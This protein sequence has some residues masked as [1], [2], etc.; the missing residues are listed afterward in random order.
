MAQ[1]TKESE[2]NYLRRSAGGAWEASKP[3]P[4]PGHVANQEHAQHLLDFAVMLRVLGPGS[5]DRVLDLGAGSCWVSEWLR[6][7]GVRTVALDIA[8]DMLRLGA[9]RLGGP[10]GLVA[11][12]MEFLPFADHSFTKACCLNAFHHVP[13]TK[14]ALGEIR[15]VLTPD[16]VAFFS[17]P[18][19]GHAANPTSVAAARNYGVLENEILIEEFMDACLEAG[20]ADVRLHPISNVMPLFVLDRRQWRD[21]RQFTASTRPVR[22]LDK[23]WRA[24]L[25]FAGVGKKDLLF[26]EAFAIRLLRELE[27][28]IE[29][30]PIVTAHRAPFVKPVL[31]RDAA[32]ITLLDAPRTVR[33]GEAMSLAGR[34]DN[35]GTTTWNR[36]A[37]EVVRLGVQLLSEDG[38]ILDKD[39]ARHDLSTVLEPGKQCA[40][41]LQLPTPPAGKYLLK[42]DLVREGVSWFELAGSVVAVHPLEVRQDTRQ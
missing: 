26:E 3:F 23:F 33:T 34:V 14:Q 11:G 29:Q 7:C 17:E 19:V 9:S 28:V 15:R 5:T 16:G 13:D 2:K 38:A 18:G 39:Y 12:D 40:F 8:W 4:P 25:E 1:D 22:A 24:L 20:F 36:D 27:P 41:R 31:I 42:I 35:V 6:R 32:Q 37:G 21:W 10:I 30:H